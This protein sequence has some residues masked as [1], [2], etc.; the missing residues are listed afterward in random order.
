MIQPLSANTQAILM[1]TAPLVTGRDGPRAQTLTPGEYK[2]LAQRL[3]DIRR[4]PAD[5][6]GPAAAAVITDCESVVAKE[7]LQGLLGRGFVLSQAVERWNARAIWVISRA[8][9][10]YPKRWKARLHGDC[11][12]VLYGCGDPNLLVTGG[13]AVVGSRDVTN[14]ILGFAGDVG[15]SSAEAGI[16]IV[17]GGARGIDTAAMNGCLDAGG[18]ACGV[19]ADSLAKHAL[20]A[21]NRRPLADGR[22]VLVSPYDPA[23]R[24]NVG[25]AMGRNK[26]IYALADRGL[27]VNC[28]PQKGG[29]WAGAIEQL[30]RYRWFPIFVRAGGESSAGNQELVRR[31]G[32]AWHDLPS[33]QVVKDMVTSEAP[34]AAEPKQDLGLFPDEEVI[35]EGTAAV[36]RRTA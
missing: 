14:D 13:L 15:R 2:R 30:N 10:I 11:P 7:R 22:L 36:P 31:G 12:P 26:L 17:S 6:I 18:R 25:H 16:T 32:V 33:A 29:T 19:V 1:L 27:V 24:F 9:A 3:R 20:D 8:D 34:R 23:A 5:M 21:S 28:E 4:Q 35:G